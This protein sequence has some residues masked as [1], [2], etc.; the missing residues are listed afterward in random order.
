MSVKRNTEIHHELNLLW[1][2]LAS[3]KHPNMRYDEMLTLRMIG[4]TDWCMKVE[5]DAATLFEQFVMMK[6]LKDLKY[7]GEE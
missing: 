1:Y 3:A 2:D 7:E 4:S 5:S 6:K